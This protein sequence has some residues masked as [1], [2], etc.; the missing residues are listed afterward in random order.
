MVTTRNRKQ[1]TPKKGNKIRKENKKD[2][3]NKPKLASKQ[4]QE[5]LIVS[6]DPFPDLEPV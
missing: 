2:G 1:D 3:K 5:I 4:K 6:S